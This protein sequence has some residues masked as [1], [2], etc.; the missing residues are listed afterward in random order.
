MPIQLPEMTC[1]FNGSEQDSCSAAKVCLLVCRLRSN[2]GL[3]KTG[4]STAYD[5][6]I[7]LVANQANAANG[8]Y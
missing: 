8:R 3:L 4:K 6:V 1:L 2:N 5:V 7:A